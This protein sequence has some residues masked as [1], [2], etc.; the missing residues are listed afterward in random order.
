MPCS[1]LILSG[2]TMPTQ[3]FLLAGAVLLTLAFS[4]LAQTP[5]KPVK[6]TGTRA[7]TAADFKSLANPIPGVQRVANVV[8]D[9]VFKT[10]TKISGG[11]REY[12]ADR[13][14]RRVVFTLEDHTAT[15][16]FS[17][18]MPGSRLPSVTHF[19]RSGPGPKG[20]PATYHEARIFAGASPVILDKA[21]RSSPIPS[22]VAT[23]IRDIG[24]DFKV[25]QQ[26][27][28]LMRIE[29]LGSAFAA[30]RGPHDAD[31]FSPHRPGGSPGNKG[32]W[33]D[34][35]KGVGRDGRASSDGEE[36]VSSDAGASSTGRGSSSTTRHGDGSTT[37]S[38]ARSS[39][40][41]SSSNTT[42]DRDANGNVTNYRDEH[43]DSAGNSTVFEGTYN[44]DT[45]ELRRSTS[46]KYAGGAWSV[47]VRNSRITPSETS[48]G[49]GY[50]A[51]LYGI[52]PWMGD[53]AYI[54]WKRESDLVRSG[55]RITQ[56]P[57]GEQPTTLIF[58]EVPKVG[59]DAVVNC[60]VSDS[61]PCAR[62][63]GVAVDPRGGFGRISQPPRG[64]TPG[65]P[66]PGETAPRPIIPKP[67][68]KP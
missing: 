3:R 36:V 40:D 10:G 13:S 63:A 30:A 61:N 65:G 11:W 37:E 21:I 54:Q 43:T 14:W 29:E 33:V 24:G 49:R 34:P 2:R 12:A 46:E 47:R 64:D 68:P 1:S 56:P 28:D 42:T 26:F 53:L 62:P 20:S 19:A 57:R 59:T 35:R 55:G 9:R 4:A 25:M 44:P 51:W 16:V 7:V 22:D 52:L 5:T 31:G 32:N 18:G 58:N 27:A 50:E 66:I 6:S 41:G 39:T 45:G 23:R 60:G 17:D 48:S 8:S 67:D 15:V 38:S